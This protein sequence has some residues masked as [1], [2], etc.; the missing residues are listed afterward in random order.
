M[1][2]L[3][4]FGGGALLLAATLSGCGGVSIEWDSAGTSTDGGTTTGDGTTT[5]SA[6]EGTTQM[7]PCA[8][9]TWGTEAPL[10]VGEGW[11]REPTDEVDTPRWTVPQEPCDSN[12]VTDMDVGPDGS[13]YLLGLSPQTRNCDEE[14]DSPKCRTAMWLRQLTSGYVD[15]WLRSFEAEEFTLRA[16]VATMDGGVVVAGDSAVNYP[17][18]PWITRYDAEGTLLWEN[19][20]E[21]DGYANGL[22]ISPEGDIVVV[23]TVDNG[24]A[25]ELWVLKLNSDGSERWTSYL[26]LDPD[27][28]PSS[29][30]VAVA[31]GPEGS[32]WV[33]GGWGES[34]YLSPGWYAQS[35]SEGVAS[36]WYF[37]GA[38]VALLDPAGQVLWVDDFGRPDPSWRGAHAIATLPDG[39]AL[40]GGIM[41]GWESPKGALAR[42]E[43]SGARVWE[44]PV[45]VEA[46]DSIAVDGDGIIHT[47]SSAMFRF[48]SDGEALAGAWNFWGSTEEREVGKSDVVAMNQEGRPLIA[49]YFLW[50]WFTPSWWTGDPGAFVGGDLDRGRSGGPRRE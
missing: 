20:I 44:V 23:G 49:G 32:I 31:V 17:H 34:S 22:A 18:S 37:D 48:D 11:I 42:Y 46:V 12:L 3:S 50:G 4:A 2:R 30:G 19:T 10:I 26:D 28:T 41:S 35:I 47:V 36:D 38:L 43:T 29:A 6:T 8:D 21:M 13:I 33:A 24:E 25:D 40:I 39:D 5:G 9:F 16:L 27:L 15:G 1:D 14:D 45:G 7:Y